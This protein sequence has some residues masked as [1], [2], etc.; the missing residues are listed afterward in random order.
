MENSDNKNKNFPTF[1]ISKESQLY[2]HNF[3]INNSSN[4]TN[5]KASS[6]KM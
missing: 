5:K 2:D 4:I 1:C 3:L 6:Q